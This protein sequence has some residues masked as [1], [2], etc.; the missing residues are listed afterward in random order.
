MP[1]SFVLKKID[2]MKNLT[3]YLF[4][5]AFAFFAQA[6]QAQCPQTDLFFSTQ[7][8]LDNFL[9]ANPNC[10]EVAGSVTLQGPGFGSAAFTN[11][12]GLSHITSIGGNLTITGASEL[13]NLD[14]LSQLTSI[15]G[16]L[17]IEA[18]QLT[19]L[20][21]LSNLSWVGNNI[22]LE[23]CYSLTNLDGFSG[24]SSHYGDFVV[25]FNQGAVESSALAN[26][27]GL[28]NL[29]IIGNVAFEFPNHAG[30]SALTDFSGF[31]GLSQIGGLTIKNASA[32]TSL[33]GLSNVFVL[34]E[35]ILDNNPAL[36]NISALQSVGYSYV[37]SIVIT[38]NSS[39][40]NCNIGLVCGNLGSGAASVVIANNAAGCDDAVEA[41]AGCGI[42]GKP[43]L[44]VKSLDMPDPIIT[45]NTPIQVTMSNTGA[46]VA[47]GPF[48]VRL[49]VKETNNGTFSLV[50]E[51][52]FSNVG[53]GDVAM[54][55]NYLAP[56]NTSSANYTFKA[57]VDE[58]NTV[59]ELDETNN[60]LEAT[61][62]LISGHIEI[63]SVTCP[64][65]FPYSGDDLISELTVTNQGWG[66]SAPKTFP[67]NQSYTQFNNVE[68]STIGTGAFSVPA[69][70]PGETMTITKNFGPWTGVLPGGGYNNGSTYYNSTIDVMNLGDGINPPSPTGVNF[71]YYCKKV[72]SDLSVVATSNSVYDQSGLIDYEITVTNNGTQDIPNVVT[73]VG[74]AESGK[75]IFNLTYV[76]GNIFHIDAIDD[77]YWHLPVLLAGES[78]TMQVSVTIQGTVPPTFLIDVHSGSGHL[79]DSDYT[80]NSSPLNFSM[81][82]AG[83]CD[84]I[85]GFTKLGEFNGHGY[86]MSDAFVP[87]TQAKTLAENAG[88]YLVTMNDQAEND[89]VKANLNNTMVFIGYNDATTEGVGQ[90][91]NNEPVTLDLSYANSATNDY[92]VMNFWAGTWQMEQ[93]GP[94]RQ[95][96]MEMDCGTVGG[97]QPDL[98]ISNVT[99][100]PASGTPNTQVDFNFDL[101]NLGNA[102]ATGSYVIG[103]YLSNDANFSTDDVLV[104]EVPTGGTP[105]GTIANVPAA[106]A[107]PGNMADGNYYVLIIADTG[108]TIAESNEN[109][110][111]ISRAFA[112][113]SGVGAG[114]SN[115]AGFTKLG[116]YNGH[117]YYLSDASENWAQAK[118]QAENAGGYLVTMNDQAEND[119]VQANLGSELVLIGYNDAVTEGVGSWATTE[120]VTLDLSYGNSPENDYAVMN[121]WAGTWQMVNQWV[122]KK[123]I[124]E[125]NC[126]TSQ[127]API[128]QNLSVAKAV[129]IHDVYPNP[130]MDNITIRVIAPEE[131]SSVF[132]V[133]DGRGQLLLSEKRDLPQGSLEV[134]FD[135]SDLPAGMYFVKEA[136]AKQYYN[137]VIMR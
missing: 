118:T 13:L 31:S 65:A 137:F 7:Q 8:D 54:V 64:N 90:W 28:S 70:Q 39:L 34:G 131:K 9:I 104:G 68:Y 135:L 17:I 60:S 80:N 22:K 84:A 2:R 57:V 121:F 116:E 43:E 75:N 38:N 44:S 100:L 96:V 88:G 122:A 127:P 18:S 41:A 74:S 109:N 46:A 130:A 19:N 42:A 59:D 93:V 67:L 20:D 134:E 113:S 79:I 1:Y 85:A 16:W 76:D 77:I 48:A 71:D 95:F 98:T 12:N 72:Q 51:Q 11:L 58:A 97:S 117:G 62:D 10:T 114:C 52:V 6:S 112:V 82:P 49:Y 133:Y 105:V 21:A 125:M 3:H 61:R 35:L 29:N 25:R 86:Y 56:Q 108:H 89:F 55:F 107:I 4:L 14:G 87:W 15:G 36:A 32:L 50:G 106:I 115:I 124:M 120:P 92:A 123:Y 129:N 102:V 81:Q 30:S 33:N 110:N 136:G 23:N 26:I 103:M 37:D 24:L 53:V 126:T 73:F 63:L 45:Q 78:R 99:N 66:T 83:G 132:N 47:T 40:S 5:L 91:A 111:M 27:N 101:N 69:L 94:Y 128:A 119:F